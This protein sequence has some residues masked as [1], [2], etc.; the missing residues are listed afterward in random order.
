MSHPYH[1]SSDFTLI[2]PYELMNTG[3]ISRSYFNLAIRVSIQSA[4]RNGYW[5]KELGWRGMQW[6]HFRLLLKQRN[7]CGWRACLIVKLEITFTGIQFQWIFHWKINGNEIQWNKTS[8]AAGGISNQQRDWDTKF[9]SPGA[10]TV[11]SHW[12]KYAINMVLWLT[13]PWI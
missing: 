11:P 10:C 6:W 7:E 4:N 13:S 8:K 5:A 9:E 12:M 2:F 3:A 1:I